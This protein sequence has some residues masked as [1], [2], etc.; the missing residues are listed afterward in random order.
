MEQFNGIPLR[1]NRYQPWIL[2]KTTA[3]LDPVDHLWFVKDC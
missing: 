3:N 1:P 2:L